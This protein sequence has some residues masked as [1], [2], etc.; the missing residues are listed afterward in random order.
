MSGW[1]EP[2]QRMLPGIHP[3]RV[4]EAKLFPG[5]P[6]QS[7]QPG[8]RDRQ[9]DQPTLDQQFTQTR[10]HVPRI[11]HML[12]HIEYGNHME[13]ASCGGGQ[14]LLYGPGV[15]VDPVGGTGKVAVLG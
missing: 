9:H 13:V 2:D 4:R 6:D 14:K 5:A 10:E 11:E 8:I 12:N 15:S 1:I 7:M 3:E